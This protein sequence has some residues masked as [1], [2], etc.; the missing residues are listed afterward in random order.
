VYIFHSMHNFYRYLD[1]E[2]ND[3][4]FYPA[5]TIDIHDIRDIRD[6]RDSPYIYYFSASKV[7]PHLKLAIRKMQLH[8]AQLP[9][10]SKWSRNWLVLAAQ[11]DLLT[12][13]DL[14]EFYRKREISAKRIQR[15]W[16]AYNLKRH[17]AAKRIQE[18]WTVARLNPYHP[19]GYS[20]IMNEYKKDGIICSY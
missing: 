12:V 14:E 8:V 2:T 4:I 10:R 6:I 11:N 3:L 19:F 17:V 7:V 16:R 20:R 9:N 13:L 1:T 18:A 15:S 5:D